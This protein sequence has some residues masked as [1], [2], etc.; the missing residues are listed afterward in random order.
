VDKITFHQ[1][2]D[3]S[4]IKQVLFPKIQM[5]NWD[6]TLTHTD[7][8]PYIDLK[9]IPNM[10]ELI[11]GVKSNARRRLRQTSRAMESH[12]FIVTDVNHQEELIYA[13]DRLVKLHQERWNDLGFTGVFYDD[14]FEDFFKDLVR[15]SSK[16]GWLWLKETKDTGGT[17]GSRMLI[18]FNGRYYD[19]ISG[20]D[21]DSPS[22]KYRPGYGLLMEVVENALD[23]K[24]RFIELLRGE[25]SYKYDFTE[26]NIKNWRISISAGLNDRW[27]DKILK[28]IL[29]VASMAYTISVREMK[30]F[31]VQYQAQGPIKALL[32]YISFRIK[33]VRE[34]LK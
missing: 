11:K 29:W 7:T 34:H 21:P 26:L 14:R 8:C 25:E 24:V 15:L 32:G 23:Q 19:Y 33:S 12:E 31:R 20:F 30:L 17:S 4:F 2:R 18:L 22:S 1:V 16:N 5:K 10:G 9:N 6:H 13:T 28:K 3:D 27:R